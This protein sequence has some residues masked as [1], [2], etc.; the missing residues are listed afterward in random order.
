MTSEGLLFSALCNP[1]AAIL[2]RSFRLWLGRGHSP[3]R[4]GYNDIA[5]NQGSTLLTADF[6]GVG[7]NDKIMLSSLKVGGYTGNAVDFCYI[8]ELNSDGSV[9]ATYYWREKTSGVGTKYTAGWYYKADTDPIGGGVV[10]DVELTCGKGLWTVCTKTG[11]KLNFSGQVRATT[12][13]IELAQGSTPTGNILPTT[14]KLST[15]KVGGYTGNAVDFCYIQKLNSDG[16]VAAT[17]YWREKTSGVGTKYTAGWY[18]KADTD[19]IGGGVVDDVDI[20]PSEGLWV[21]CTKTGYTL[22]FPELNLGK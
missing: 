14:I 3:N 13:T 12:K 7:E 21:V 8:Q 9:A 5:L 18:Y 17:Y 15:L 20:T 16:S 4:V 19:P 11:Y 10:D 2:P 22:T 1:N 6:L